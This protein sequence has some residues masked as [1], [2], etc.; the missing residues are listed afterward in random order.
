MGKC[1]ALRFTAALAGLV[2]LASI[3]PAQEQIKARIVGGNKTDIKLHPWQVAFE[4]DISGIRQFCGGS[5][6]E[7]RWVLTAAHCFF[8]GKNGDLRAEPGD[9]RAKSGVTNYATSGSWAQIERVV[10]HPGYNPNTDVGGHEHDL[11]LVKLRSPAAGKSIQL[12]AADLS[13]PVGQQLEVTGWGETAYLKGDAP[14]VLRRATVPYQDL[15]ACN[16]PAAYKGAIKASM[17]CAGRQEGGIDACRG[18]SGG[19]LV[20]R[21]QDGQVLVG[22]VSWGIDCG[23]AS[24]YGVYT[25]VSSYRDWI[26]GILASDPK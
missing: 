14:K 13:V 3:V 9:V 17:M 1:A 26:T 2:N 22:V 20:W 5:I 18:D 24:K 10:V 21:K 8:G 6:I 19:P 12:A 23:K 11:A 16:A 4:V 7:P 15:A 25:R